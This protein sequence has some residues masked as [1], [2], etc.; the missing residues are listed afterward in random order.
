MTWRGEG[1]RVTVMDEVMVVGDFEIFRDDEY[2]GMFQVRPYGSWSL[3][4]ARFFNSLD[5]AVE[6]AGGEPDQMR[7]KQPDLFS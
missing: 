1:L 5:E 7:K 2:Y 3:T 6:F 4:N